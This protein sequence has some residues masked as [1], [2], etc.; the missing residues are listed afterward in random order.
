MRQEVRL[1][2]GEER[3]FDRAALRELRR[4]GRRICR[5]E[6]CLT[7]AEKW[8]HRYGPRR[9]VDV[10]ELPAGRELLSHGR[11]LGPQLRGRV[12]LTP[13]PSAAHR[14]APDGEVETG[15]VKSCQHGLFDLI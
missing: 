14:P 8:R 15:I 6:V 3:L 13:Q 10:Q 1:D 4:G 11:Q 7:P 12:R 9:R 5:N 2:E